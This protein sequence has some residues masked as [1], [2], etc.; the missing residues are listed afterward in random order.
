MEPIVIH[1][2]SKYWSVKQFISLPVKRGMVGLYEI[3]ISKH[4]AMNVFVS[5]TSVSTHVP[6]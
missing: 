2:P 1:Y 6:V 4:T 5:T 3:P